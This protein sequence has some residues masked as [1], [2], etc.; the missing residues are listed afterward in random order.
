MKTQMSRGKVVLG[1]LFLC[2][3]SGWAVGGEPG[4][5]RQ[6]MGLYDL[7]ETEATARISKE[8]VASDIYRRV[9]SLELEGYAGSWFDGEELNV[10]TSSRFDSEQIIEA[11]AIPVEVQFSLEDLEQKLSELK[12]SVQDFSSARVD[13]AKNSIVIGLNDAGHVRQQAAIDRVIQEGFRVEFEDVGEIYPSSGPVRGGDGTRN[14]SWAQQHGGSWPCSVG[15]SVEGGFLTA[16]HCGATNN[17]IGNATSAPLGTTFRSTWYES[18]QMD[19]GWVATLP[20]WSPGPTING[21]SDGVI[22][23]A[24]K[25][26]G[27]NSTPVGTTV[28]RYGQSSGGPWCGTVAVI[29][30]TIWSGSTQGGYLPGMTRVTGSCTSDGDSGGP[31]LSAGAQAQGTNFG[32]NPNTC[33]GTGLVWFLP[34]VSSLSELNKI[35]LTAHGASAP[36]SSGFLCPDLDNSGSGTYTCRFDHYLS[37]GNTSVSWT[38]NTGAYSSGLEVW[39]TCNSGQTVIVTLSLANPYGTTNRNKSFLCPMQPIP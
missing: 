16:G 29:G 22:G 24:A 5:V 23:V 30:E 1:V 11:G 36:A 28:C 31:F 34:V 2:V 15:V 6:V 10:A 3:S 17:S 8:Q 35:M 14:L 38:S 13:Y 20:G 21:Y 39:G 12:E 27:M 37:Q 33:P 19:A 32:G 26:S 4:M 7:N 9:L 18:T 25:W